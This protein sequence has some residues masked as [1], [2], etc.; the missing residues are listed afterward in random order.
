MMGRGAR[1]LMCSQRESTIAYFV[2]CATLEAVLSRAPGHFGANH[3]Y[4]HATEASLHPERSLQP[5]GRLESVTFEPG[6]SHL[7]HMPSHTWSRTG[8]Y[9]AAA[10]SNARATRL[11]EAYLKP[12]GRL[13]H[14]R[15]IQFCGGIGNGARIGSDPV[16]ALSTSTM[17]MGQAIS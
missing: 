5:A 17:V 14:S 8:F 16:V 10:A 1:V 2:I 15:T 4:V 7:T 13:D 11:D 3:L 6:A 12:V 9:Q